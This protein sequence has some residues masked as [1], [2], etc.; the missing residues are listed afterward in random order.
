MQKLIFY[1][2]DNW[3]AIAAIILS[4]TSFCFNVLK[5]I[6]DRNHAHDKELLEQLKQ[7]MQLAWESVEAG[8]GSPTNIRSRW[9]TSARH[10]TRYRELK[11]SLKTRLFRIM[12]DEQE[13][14]WSNRFY[15]LLQRI[16]NSTFFECINPEELEEEQIEPRSA[17][18]VHSMSVWP[19]DKRDPIDAVAF[20]S[21]V[22]RYGLF[23]PQYKHFREYIQRKHPRLAENVKKQA[24]L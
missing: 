3:I 23:S 10:I 6:K 22:E 11:Q 12:C 13:E 14:Y 9:L 4:I 17:A 21:I 5:N 1:L 2:R 16:P 7:S 18:I 8:D 24:S 20:E 15:A 19:K